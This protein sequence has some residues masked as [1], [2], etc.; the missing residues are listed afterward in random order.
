[1]FCSKIKDQNQKQIYCHI[2]GISLDAVAHNNQKIEG[3]RD[4]KLHDVRENTTTSTSKDHIY[5]YK[6]QI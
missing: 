1:M 3:K 6:L 5:N 4:Y 2:Q